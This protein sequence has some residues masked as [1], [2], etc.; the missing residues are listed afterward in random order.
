M[1][2]L[3]NE[4]LSKLLS[5]VLRHKP[6]SI[7][8]T[9]DSGGWADIDELISKVNE[10]GTPFTDEQ[11]ICVVSSDDKKRYEI[12][13]GGVYIRACQGHS[14]NV[15][16]GLNKVV[17]PVVLYHGTT[18]RFVEAIMKS[19]LSKMSRQH[20]HLSDNLETAKMVGNTP[21]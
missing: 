5:Y 19:G 18:E 1:V 4:K 11:L 21:R 9:L 17:P 14:I 2:I 20:V 12:S 16:L 13:E 15:D 10:S 3:T 7:G 6:E 8:L